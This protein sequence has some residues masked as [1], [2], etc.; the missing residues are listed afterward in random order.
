MIFTAEYVSL[1]SP[2]NVSYL[3]QQLKA[4]LKNSIYNRFFYLSFWV[5]EELLLKQ[6]FNNF[7]VFP[8]KKYVWFPSKEEAYVTGELI[9]N[10]GGK[11]VIKACES[12]KVQA[13]AWLN[14]RPLWFLDGKWQM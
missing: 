10:E 3:Q 13:I 8:G 5:L 14:G 2:E 9:K 1:Q 4:I 6:K 11:C 12:G 7:D